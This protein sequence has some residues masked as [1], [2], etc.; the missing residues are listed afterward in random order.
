MK[1]LGS[2]ASATTSAAP[3]D[4]PSNSSSATGN[5]E[6]G[7]VATDETR[8][9]SLIGS[10]VRSSSG[11][12]DRVHDSE[13]ETS[14]SPATGSFRQNDDDERQVNPDLSTGTDDD[15]HLATM[16]L[17]NPRGEH[18]GDSTNF[19]FFDQENDFRDGQMQSNNLGDDRRNM[20]THVR[21][22]IRHAAPPHPA[23]PPPAYDDLPNQNS[24]GSEDEI[25]DILAA[26]MGGLRIAEDG[27]L[28]YYG[29]TSNLH[30][31]PNGSHS[32]SC[33][34]IRHVETEGLGVLERLGLAQEISLATEAHLAKLYFCW[35]DPAIHVVDE[36][37]F[38]A[39]KE[40][41][42]V[43]GKKSPYYSETLNNA[44]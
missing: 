35:E 43:H 40:N 19:M 29:P 10:S 17:V 4:S 37:T 39:E 24:S 36:A 25:T 3:G 18:H 23:H 31:H 15:V 7:G 32:L 38:F 22:P 26:R 1:Q 11:V 16:G 34:N 28:R 44:M 12:D 33:L 20:F 41:T 2:N 30:V 42:V 6:D 9:D 8:E 13:D 14:N 27:E 5:Q 21:S